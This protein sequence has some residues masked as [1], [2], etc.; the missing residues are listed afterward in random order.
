ML[1]RHRSLK[2]VARGEMM[3]RPVGTTREKPSPVSMHLAEGE[4]DVRRD[5]CQLFPS[6]PAPV[7]LRS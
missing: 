5:Q 3:A 1:G 2:V 6:V 7:V 4:N